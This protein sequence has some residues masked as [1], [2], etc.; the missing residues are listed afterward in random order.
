MDR[1]ICEMI[2]EVKYLKLKSRFTSAIFLFRSYL[3]SSDEEKEDH[4]REYLQFLKILYLLLHTTHLNV[5]SLS[6]IPDRERDVLSLLEIS[7]RID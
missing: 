2:I 3:S 4:L 6:F 5:R 7:Q 1:L